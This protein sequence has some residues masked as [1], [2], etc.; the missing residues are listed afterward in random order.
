M[1]LEARPRPRDK[2]GRLWKT[3]SNLD[4]EGQPGNVVKVESTRARARS[5]TTIL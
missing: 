3:T 1:F 5:L 4:V 2:E